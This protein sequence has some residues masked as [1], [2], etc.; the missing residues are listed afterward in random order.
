MGRPKEFDSEVVL[1]AATNCF[2]ADGISRTSI[3]SLVDAMKIQRSSFYNSFGSREGILATVLERY[4]EKSPLNSLIKNEAGP[5]D[6]QPE[7][8]LI[9]LLLDFS[10]FLVEEGN[11]RG[12]LIFNGLAELRAQ[13]G[14]IFEIFQDYYTNLTGGLSRLLDRIRAEA[15]AGDTLGHISLHHV[16]C[17]L[18]GMAHYSKLD[19]TENRLSQ[20]GLD[21]LSGL[22]PYFAAQ[23][24]NDEGS[25]ATERRLLNAARMRA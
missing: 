14:Q 20:I 3:S 19:P 13:D 4:M 11:G 24:K 23:I 10:H 2:W 7:I 16:L 1:D 12:C 5:D 17:I 15:G 21:Q 9:D 6:I 18:I 8:E 22:S 25:R